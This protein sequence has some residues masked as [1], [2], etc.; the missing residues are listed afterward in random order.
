MLQR[1]YASQLE[2]TAVFPTCDEETCHLFRDLLDD[3]DTEK[4]RV[5]CRTSF[6]PP[7][8]RLEIWANLLAVHRKS[9]DVGKWDDAFNLPNQA[10]IHEECA[11][12]RPKLVGFG[13]S[14]VVRLEEL[15]TLYCKRRGVHYLSGL[16]YLLAPFIWLDAPLGLAFNLSYALIERY[17][18]IYSNEDI[19]LR[20]GFAALRLLLTY[21]N[22]KLAHF[23]N[24]R[25]VSPTVYSHSW[26]LTL[27][28]RNGRMT[29]T[30]LWWDWLFCA[31]SS[32]LVYFVS[33]DILLQ[34]EDAIYE[35]S[36]TVSDDCEELLAFVASLPLHCSTLNT[37]T[38]EDV[39]VWR[40]RVDGLLQKTP[41]SFILEMQSLL[42]APDIDSGDFNHGMDA[43]EYSLC[44]ALEKALVL[45][46]SVED[47]I[48]RLH[49]HGASWKWVAHAEDD[50]SGIAVKY[51][52]LDIRSEDE[53][54]SCHLPTALSFPM[55]RLLQDPERMEAEIRSFPLLEGTHFVV[56]GSTAALTDTD[57]M[58]AQLLQARVPYV[59]HL[60]GGMERVHQLA[61]E[62][63]LELVEHHP[64]KCG[65]CSPSP[66]VSRQQGRGIKEEEKLK[67]ARYVTSVIHEDVP[68]VQRL[69]R[70]DLQ[71]KGH[72]I[73]NCQDGY[74]VALSQHNLLLLDS[75]GT[76]QWAA[77]KSALQTL[78]P[79]TVRPDALCILP[80]SGDTTN[81]SPTRHKKEGKES[82]GDAWKILVMSSVAEAQRLM[83]AA[84]MSFLEDE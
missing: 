66:K 49:L 3:G 84:E 35:A 23:L 51:L 41:L 16:A 29:E 77:A 70:R 30:V 4:I 44:E 83:T 55:D 15:C 19:T 40:G 79:S 45:N 81:R 72:V 54:A 10:L 68:V 80:I 22:P 61:E 58:L 18:P 37:E 53:Y 64:D 50:H 7:A 76:L 21:H 56:V 52:L 20:G 74:Y 11:K 73:F 28:A 62:G 14:R 13:E 27:L 9:G 65:Y 57:L 82:V 47:V 1:S 2:D 60:R 34:H 48:T 39:M 67:D 78:R 12:A 24:Q 17:C 63:K 31:P 32:L 46:V 25:R 6:L 5:V 36:N 69:S 71:E 42:A 59:S 75:E 43:V 8:M 26:L 38:I 33:L